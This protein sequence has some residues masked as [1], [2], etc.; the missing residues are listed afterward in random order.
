MPS[1]AIHL[2]VAKRY[3]QKNKGEI[4][5]VRDFYDGNIAPD[6]TDNKMKTHYSTAPTGNDIMVNAKCKV[7][8]DKVFRLS[9]DTDFGKGV[10]LHLLTDYVFYNFFFDGDFI[11]STTYDDFSRDLYASYNFINAWLAD[12][13]KISY[14]ETS[15]ADKMNSLVH[16]LQSERPEILSRGTNILADLN[17]VSR[18]IEYMSDFDLQKVRQTQNIGVVNF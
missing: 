3:L 17:K 4:A 15:Y 12:T 18:F 10:F 13:Y 8:L 9:I 1:Y 11:K 6:L 14:Y 5:N 7:G 16:E 2:A